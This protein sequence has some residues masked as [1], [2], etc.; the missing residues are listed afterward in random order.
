MTENGPDQIVLR[1][2]RTIDQKVDNL[3]DDMREVKTRIGLMEQ[4][5]ASL[6]NRIDRIELRLDRIETRLGL[7]EA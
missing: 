1:L 3:R 6:S 5:Y 7:I 4:Q 2:L